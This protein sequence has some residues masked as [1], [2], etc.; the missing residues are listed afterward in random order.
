MANLHKLLNQLRYLCRGGAAESQSC[1]LPSFP[2][3]LIRRWA[4]MDIGLR[5]PEA[6]K[7]KTSR[8][9]VSNH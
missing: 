9:S 5:A 3:G 2:G 1:P 7:E 6:T 4:D 8:A